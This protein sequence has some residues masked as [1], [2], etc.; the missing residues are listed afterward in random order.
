MPESPVFMKRRD[1]YVAVAAFGRKSVMPGF[2]VQTQPNPAA[3][4]RIGI[5]ATRK[6][7]GA[8]VRNRAKRRLRALCREIMPSHAAPGNDFVLIARGTTPT[9]PYGTLRDDLVNALRKLGLLK[10][11]GSRL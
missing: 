9:I 8:V 2:I 10:T 7:G 5:T 6:I 4:I 11:E 1:D 3:G